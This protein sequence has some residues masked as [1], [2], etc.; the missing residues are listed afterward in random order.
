[1]TGALLAGA[2]ALLAWPGGAARRRERLRRLVGRSRGTAVRSVAGAPAAWPLLAGAAGLAAGALAGPPL[3]AVLAAAVSVGAARTVLRQ[4]DRRRDEQ[5]LDVLADAL[6][7]LA[8]ELR[9]GR[10]LAAATASAVAV[11]PDA[12][13][14]RGLARALRAPDALPAGGSSELE[15]ALERLAAA[16]RL[17]NRTGCSLAAVAGAVEDDLRARRRQREELG[18]VTAGPRASAALLAGLPLLALAMGGGIGARPWT[19]LTTTPVGQVLLVAG[20][21]LEAT[22]LAWSAW[23]VRRALR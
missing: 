4:S 6:A 7:A 23:L 1:M 13:A 16:V 11:V 20:V 2:L 17:S 21:A 3:V 18:S 12:D 15:R 22:G 14:A 5:V 9:S 10:P 8:A 19:V